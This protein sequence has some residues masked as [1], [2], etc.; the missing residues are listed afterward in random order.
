M[1]MNVWERE[2]YMVVEREFDHDLHQFDVVKDGEIV[3]T[4]VPADIDNQQE[5]M[6]ALDDGE[7]VQGW[8]DGMGNTITLK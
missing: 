5:I 3:A 8:E 1:E 4:I 7:D 6:N 2:S